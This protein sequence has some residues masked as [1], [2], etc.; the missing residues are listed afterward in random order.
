MADILLADNAVYSRFVFIQTPPFGQPINKPDLRIARGSHSFSYGN[1]A[2]K[3][4]RADI[5]G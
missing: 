4:T 5:L 2:L 3:I 1:D